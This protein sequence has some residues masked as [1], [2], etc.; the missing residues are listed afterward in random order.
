MPSQSVSAPGGSL[1][2]AGGALNLAA[3][4]AL[5]SV[6]PLLPPSRASASIPSR[7]ITRSPARASVVF[8][9]LMGMADADVQMA[10]RLASAVAL[11]APRLSASLLT[12][13]DARASTSSAQLVCEPADSDAAAG[14]AQGYGVVPD[15]DGTGSTAACSPM[16]TAAGQAHPPAQEQ[17][18]GAQEQQ[19]EQQPCPADGYDSVPIL[20]VEHHSRPQHDYYSITALLDFVSF[21]YLALFY[22]VVMS[23][24][25]SLADL[26]D[27]K[28]LPWDYLTALL[29][30]FVIT[31][32]D[33][34]V[35]SLGSQ[36]GKAMLL[37][38]QLLLFIPFCMRLFWS[39]VASS[40]SS[41]ARQHERVFMVL[42]AAS[43]VSSALQLRSGFPPRASFD[44]GGRQRF[45]F[46]STA[47]VWH[48]MGFY[49]FQVGWCGFVLRI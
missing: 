41:A 22:Q 7:S 2:A 39:P 15:G 47:D 37:L 42:K 44:G 49:V 9:A 25:R 16:S 17:L 11:T 5:G 21:V 45:V 3:P 26:T 29:L 40:S 43:W 10:S 13:S 31:V 18:E 30:L 12:R 34:L 24:A 35:Y 32:V 4:E 33:R 28:Q 46:Y 23:S 1:T 20:G 6:S 48:L 27:E 36:L 8:D 38:A 14:T 19:Q